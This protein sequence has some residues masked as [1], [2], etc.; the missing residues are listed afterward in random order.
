[1][2]EPKILSATAAAE[3]VDE[4]KRVRLALEESVQLQSHYAKLL[5]MYDSGE[6]RGFASAD[7]WIERLI[8]I[9]KIPK[10]E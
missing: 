10:P 9:G 6:R 3:L 5:N 2:S 8:E 7:V 1:M 4:I